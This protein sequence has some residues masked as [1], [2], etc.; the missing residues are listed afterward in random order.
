[1]SLMDMLRADHLK[2]RKAHM[3]VEMGLY[4]SLIGEAAMVGKNKGNR[5]STDEEVIATIQKFIK[6]GTD[7]RDALAKHPNREGE[8]SRV[9]AM[10]EKFNTELSILTSY[11]PQQ[12]TEN[13]LRNAVK[14][15]LDDTPSNM[16]AVMKVLKERHGGKYDGK[17]AAGIV[18]SVLAGA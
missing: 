11:L 15:I 18:K 2:A 13:D 8:G 7:A 14:T 6:N 10:V 17:M 16:G 1:M 5:E 12:M 9:P 4:S 3:P